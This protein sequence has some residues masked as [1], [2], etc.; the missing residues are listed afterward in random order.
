MPT[1]PNMVLCS[2]QTPTVLPRPEEKMPMEALSLGGMEKEKSRTEQETPAGL[3]CTEP[4]PSQNPVGRVNK[5][6]RP[7]G[8]WGKFSVDAHGPSLRLAPVR[9]LSDSL[10]TSLPDHPP[11][12]NGSPEHR[13]RRTVA[14]RIVAEH[15][16]SFASKEVMSSAASRLIDASDKLLLL[17][18]LRFDPT[19]GITTIMSNIFNEMAPKWRTHTWHTFEEAFSSPTL[20]YR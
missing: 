18:S 15:T 20:R 12:E 6:R 8:R 10:S 14:W 11:P 13:F 7:I 9:S 2:I 5:D 19:P 4:K 16:I 17:F 1:L 3:S